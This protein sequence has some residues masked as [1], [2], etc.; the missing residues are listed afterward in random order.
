MVEWCVHP[1]LVPREKVVYIPELTPGHRPPLFLDSEE[2]IYHIQPT[3]CYRLEIDILEV[4][5]WHVLFSSSVSSED[6]DSSS[7]SPASL[8]GQD[9]L[10]ALMRARPRGLVAAMSTIKLPRSLPRYR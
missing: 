5:D 9:R 2:I 3:L 4:E 7:A 1:D 10:L 6:S 8:I